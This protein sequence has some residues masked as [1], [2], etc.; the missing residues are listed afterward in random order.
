MFVVHHLNL[1]P[2]STMSI[3]VT[4][5]TRTVVTLTGVTMVT[6]ERVSKSI[7]TVIQFYK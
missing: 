7:L 1:L 2:I 3:M 4:M 6:R 5:M